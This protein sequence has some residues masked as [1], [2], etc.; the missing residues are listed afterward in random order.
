[1]NDINLI[2]SC[3][4]HLPVQYTSNIIF[5]RQ[6][7]HWCCDW[8]RAT[9]KSHMQNKPLV[10]SKCDGQDPC[11]RGSNTSGRLI[12]PHRCWKQQIWGSSSWQRFRCSEY[13][14]REIVGFCP[15]KRLGC[16][17]FLL[18]KESVPPGYLQ[19]QQPQHTDQLHSLQEEF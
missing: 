9:P 18:Q 1:M 12:W 5:I 17:K 19:F 7:W 15:G 11:I 13:G 14:R 16:R 4:A 3:Q 8:Q 6:K 10:C 2:D